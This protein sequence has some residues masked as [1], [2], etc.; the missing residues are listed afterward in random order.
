M[1][2]AKSVVETEREKKGEYKHKLTQLVECE[3]VVSEEVVNAIGRVN[4]TVR[5]ADENAPSSD[6]LD[7]DLE[8]QYKD[9]NFFLD[10]P[11]DT[12]SLTE[13]RPELPTCVRY[14]VRA[15]LTHINMPK[16]SPLSRGHQ[17]G[18]TAIAAFATTTVYK[19]RCWNE[20]VIDQ[21]IEDGDTFYCESYKEI[22]TDDRRLLTILHLQR[23]L[24]V[25]HKLTV[26][27]TIEDAAYAG[28]FRSSE[29][30]E[31]HLV[32]ALDLF[33]KRYNAGILSSSV[34]NIA[35]WKDTKYYNIFD[36]QA[37]KENCEPAADGLS[38]TAKLFLVKDMI[39][40]LF[41]IL[42]KS[43]VKNEPF[44]LYA[45][46]ISGVDHYT[47]PIAAVDTEKVYA[48]AVERRPSSYKMQDKYR[49]V[50]QG[51]Y[52]LMHPALPS[53]VRGRTHMIIALAAL[54]Y[55]RLVNSNRWTSGLVD[56]IFNQSNIYFIDLVRV[57]DKDLNDPEFELKMDDAMGDVILGVY[58]AKVKIRTNVV[59]GYGQKRG[60]VAF[61]TGFREF[62]E[63]QNCG[64]LEIKGIYYAIWR[65]DDTYYYMDPYACDDEGFR[66]GTAE[67]D[68][69]HKP[70]EAACVTMNSSINQIL[71]T[72]MENTGSRDKDPFLI[73]GV[74]VLYVKT[75]TKPGGP[76]E[77]VIYREKGTNR[78]PHA[79]PT[80]I[81]PATGKMD[82]DEFVDMTPTIRPELLKMKDV[83][84]QVPPLM[85]DAEAYMMTDDEPRSYVILP[86]EEEKEPVEDLGEEEEEEEE[87][88]KRDWE[89][90]AEEEEEPAEKLPEEPPVE[91]MIQGYLKVNPNRLVL[92]GSKNCLDEGFEIR[93]RGK[94]GLIAA[95]VAMAYRKLKNP[96]LWRNM[97][98]DQLIDV[99]DK[100]YGDIV[101][102][103]RKGSPAVTDERET[104]MGE[105]E[106]EEEE[107]GEEEEEERLLPIPSHLDLNMLPVRLKFGEN[108]VFFKSKVD[109]I[110]GDAAPL[111]NLAEALE[112]YFKKYH[113]LVLENKQLMYGI[114]KDHDQF[115]LFNPY[116]TDAEGWRLR[117]YPASFAVLG[118]LNEL[119]DLLHGVIEFND[120][121]F[122][123]H[124]VALDSIQP[125]K[126][127]VEYEIV[128]PDDEIELFKTRF[129][130]ITDQDIQTLEDE[131]RPVVE[132]EEDVGIIDV[133]MGE[134]EE[135]EEEEEGGRRRAGAGPTE[136]SEKPIVNPLVEVPEKDQPDTPYRL[137]L[138]LLTAG[139]KIPEETEEEM[140]QVHE[141]KALEKLKY[142][143]PPPYVMPS[144][145]TLIKLLEAKRAKRSIPSLVSRFSI[146]SRLDVKKKGGFSAMHLSRS[147]VMSTAAPGVEGADVPS[148]KIKLCPKRYLFSRLLP[149]CLLPMRAI[150][151]MYIQYDAPYG[152]EV[153]EPDDENPRD[154]MVREDLPEAPVGVRI[155]PT[156]VPLGPIIRTPVPE[157]RTGS[158]PEKKKRKCLLAKGDVGDALME[159]VLCN[160]EDLLLELFFPD[161]KVTDQLYME[162][163]DS[164]IKISRKGSAESQETTIRMK[165]TASKKKQQK[166]SARLK[167]TDDGIRILQ[168]SMCLENRAEIEECHFKCCFFAAL[169]CILAKIKLDPDKFSPTTLDQFVFLG[170][171]IYQKTGKLRFK[172]YRW[173]HHIEIMNTIYNVIT[174]QAIY[175]DP[176]STDQDDL[177]YTMDTFFE[178]NQTGIIVFANCSYAF[179]T[180][181]GVYYLFDP[182]AC[183]ENGNAAEGGYSCFM[184]FC[185]LNGLLEKIEANVGENTKKPYRLYTV[186]I[187][188]METKRRRKKRR[189]KVQHCVDKP[190]MEVPVE[191]PP[192]V[193]LSAESSVSLIEQLDWVNAESKTCFG[194]DMTIP[195]FAPIKFC[196]AAMLEVT[197]LENEITTPIL[198]P[199]K[200]IT[201]KITEDM[202]EYEIAKL[203][204]RK[205]IV[206][207]RFK[208]STIVATPLDLCIMA[209]SLIHDP[210][211][212]SV[213]TVRGLFGA[214]LDYSFDILLA[215]QDSTVSDMTDGMLPEFEIANYVFRVVFVPLHYGTLYATEG[216]NL[217]MSL[218]KIFDTPSY[219]G[220]ILVCGTVHIGVMKNGE[221]HFA[222]WI[223]VGTKNLRIITATDMK[224]FLRLIVKVID[225][226]EEEIF[227]MRVITVSYAQK[228]DPDCSDTKGL[229]ESVVPATSLPEIHRM[230]TEPYDLEAI[231]RPSVPENKPIFVHG[232]VALNNRDSIMEPRV[233]RCYFVAILAVMVQRD[234]VQSPMP[235]MVDKVL[236]VAESVYREFSEPKFHTEHILRNLTIMNRIFDLR[237]CTSPLVLLTTNPRTMRNDF[238]LQVRKHLKKFFKVYA[239]GLIHFTNCCYGFWY[240]RSTNAYYYLDP[241]Q[242]NEKGRKVSSGGKACLCIFPGLCPMVKNM[243]FNQLAETTGFFIH[244]IHVDSINVPPFNTFKEDPM[245]LYLDYHWNFRHAPDIVKSNGKKKKKKS[246]EEDEGKVK[247]FWNNY[248]VEVS[249]LIYSVWGT[250][251]AYDSRF[252]DRAG[253]NQAAICVAVLAMQYLSH[254]SRWGPAILDSAVICGDSYYTESVRGAIQKCAKYYNHFNL[255]PCFKIFP[256][257]WVIDFRD[258][259]CGVLY[260]AK[261]KITLAAALN[262]AFDESPN[263]LIDCNKIVLAGL[264]AKDGFYVADPGWVGPP[265]FEKDHG[266]I[267][268]LRCRNMN[269]LVY[270][271][272]KMLNTNKRID[273]RITP[274][275]FTF[276]QEDFN[277]VDSKTRESKKKVFLE[278]L[279][280]TP[281][282]SHDPGTLIP[283]AD[284]VPDEDSYLL[285]HKNLST[286]IKKGH[287]LEYPELPSVEPVLSHDAMHSAM[288]ST[289]WHLNLGQ[290]DPLEKTE[291]K[292]DPMLIGHDPEKCEKRVVGTFQPQQ[293][294]QMSITDL[295]AACDDYP[296]L[297]D[298]K[299][300][301]TTFERPVVCAK[302]T[303]FLTETAREEFNTWTMDMRRSVYTT[304]KHRLPKP[305][306]P[307]SASIAEEDAVDADEGASVAAGEDA[308]ADEVLYN[309]EATEGTE[310]D[311]VT[312]AEAEATT[313]DD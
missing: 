297:V 74:R 94:Q 265:L 100:T 98:I 165:P 215:V 255:Q 273:F 167:L 211:T 172:P 125:G 301:K 96:T 220:A 216:W 219:T 32:K 136:E 195:G 198:A 309:T 193:M 13:I 188:H 128:V 269:C 38:G 31:L 240:S 66:S 287:K 290:A 185:D 155:R 139:L 157:K 52:H 207:R 80:A 76:L 156:L 28:K 6:E 48:H 29:P 39:G 205:R 2:R 70:G 203:L 153:E 57:I 97:D 69:S 75:G 42:E 82:D 230:P 87:P 313:D 201:K 40:V 184:E 271:V 99:S 93:S 27:V 105:A 51:S 234:I 8:E 146:D 30:T 86:P 113:E 63:S 197:V 85:K 37:R 312:E 210:I 292:F 55:S 33:F 202:D 151:D 65:H 3:E 110:R 218:Q 77:Y 124:F 67:I 127:A 277:F 296:R 275:A 282:K 262:K 294:V 257:L 260:G 90:M 298:F 258:S 286:G 263:I 199:F 108:D 182:Y 189:K 302:A 106:E 47:Q 92:Q 12:Y 253:R 56:L 250:I 129:L 68:G 54:V 308:D 14:G 26:N 59:P 270:A 137:N 50:L 53:L 283:G 295:L 173:F 46:A 44:V 36:G 152:D 143:H 306:K 170:D 206:E 62:F 24:C 11:D 224:E 118:T 268:V 291:P 159:K 187:A 175:A 164:K 169:L 111:A 285:Y 72:I 158:C 41:I 16:F 192:E 141:Q 79:F 190:E 310:D 109:I 58:S 145:K 279:R 23:T 217:A 4:E 232:T 71:E 228:M 122:T 130:P 241:Y 236:E 133:T 174:K 25:Q 284:I 5:A 307:P 162:D 183:D 304:Y 117:D 73:H 278:P 223:V 18:A 229:H 115:F 78:R 103:I 9:L 214:V 181:N 213:K 49:A 238:Y 64:L 259:V 134:E 140:R 231:F 34:L 300:E 81:V 281:G 204:I 61:D 227:V 311:T 112:C 274:V 177:E 247:Q 248:A 60:K 21:I 222:W 35:I 196:N 235:E 149:I 20:A 83:A 209:W 299:S 171:K 88:A 272:V 84:V 252:G 293:S 161:F 245:W 91:K 163:K 89:E 226:P 251:G 1:E 179:W 15:G 244:R 123:I 225:Q 102:W 176:E 237:D 305:K 186:C 160:T 191:E 289:T 135:E 43:H 114:W 131:L 17:G 243:C 254:P 107:G 7:E 132:E 101:E 142:E 239:S 264:A 120:P 256:H 180:A 154:D 116:G 249:N 95:L 121:S 144:N 147:A 246:E 242:C 148:K 212:W 261:N 267:Y 10:L 178:K 126:F 303:S 194:Y 266:A 22:N 19:S 166:R 150:D 276:E 104:M 45:I 119:I 138:A 221:N 208:T 288:I 168:G 233:K 200:K 280:T